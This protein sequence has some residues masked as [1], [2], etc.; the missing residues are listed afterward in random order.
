MYH[1]RN[2]NLE[3]DLLKDYNDTFILH[4]LQFDVSNAQSFTLGKFF[5]KQHTGFRVRD[6][7]SDDRLKKWI[8]PVAT[9]KGTG[10][11]LDKLKLTNETESEVYDKNKEFV[12]IAE[13]IDLPIYMF[14]YNIEMTQFAYTDLMKN[15]DQEEC[16]D[17]TL[18][19]RHHAQFISHQIADEARV[20]NHKRDVEDSDFLRLV[21]HH[22]VVSVDM[23]QDSNHRAHDFSPMPQGLEEHDVYLINHNVQ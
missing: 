14:T 17:K 16:I 5:N 9:F 2:S 7:K 21:K 23:S 22:K 19:S 13:G 12:A 4:P 1:Y 15:P 8:T 18:L 6:L 11:A 3:V 20:N 10:D